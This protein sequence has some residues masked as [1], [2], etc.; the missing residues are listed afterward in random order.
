[1]PWLSITSVFKSSGSK[2]ETGVSTH[3]HA[4][5][6]IFTVASGLLYEVRSTQRLYTPPLLIYF[7]EI[8]V[9]HDP[10]CSSQHRAHGEVL[11]YRELPVAVL[12][13]TIPIYCLMGGSLTIL[14]RNLFLTSLRNTVSST[15]SSPT[16]GRRG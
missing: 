7:P 14:R 2:A 4:E 13:G 15:N 3:R 8:R 12:P 10:E 9:D 16:S 1:M 5:I 6:N 11:V